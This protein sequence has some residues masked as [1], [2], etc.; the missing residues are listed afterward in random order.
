MFRFHT[1]RFALLKACYVGISAGYAV[2]PVP[3]DSYENPIIT[4]TK[5]QKEKRV[6]MMFG[7]TSSEGD[8]PD[9]LLAYIEGL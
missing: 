2:E 3:Q 8:I 5:Q 6:G 4:S 1:P 7:E 9:D